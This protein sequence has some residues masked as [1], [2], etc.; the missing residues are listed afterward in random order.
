MLSSEAEGKREAENH[1]PGNRP[2]TH[3]E[4]VGV[5]SGYVVVS[6]ASLFR[7]SPCMDISLM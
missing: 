4:L 1:K 6:K 3:D 5:E 2:G 7:L